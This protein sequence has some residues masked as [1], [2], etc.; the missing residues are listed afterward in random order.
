MLYQDE[1]YEDDTIN[2]LKCSS[3]NAEYCS[4]C[5]IN[6]DITGLTLSDSP[7]QYTQYKKALRKLK[8]VK[9]GA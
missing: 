7:V 6:Q 4:S 8:Y 9:D 2:I 1:R 3:C 5:G